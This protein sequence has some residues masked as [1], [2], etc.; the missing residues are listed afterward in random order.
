MPVIINIIGMNIQKPIDFIVS[1]K[2]GVVPF[3]NRMIPIPTIAK[4]LPIYIPI[5]LIFTLSKTPLMYNAPNIKAPPPSR[6][7]APK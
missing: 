4:T 6:K 7:K 3:W 5:T 2:D 1:V